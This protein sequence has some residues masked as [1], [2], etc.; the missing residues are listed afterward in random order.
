MARSAS[1][2]PQ[3]LAEGGIIDRQRTIQ[4]TF[5]GVTY[6]GHFGDTVASALLA[7]GVILTGRS[8]KYHRPRGIFSAGSEEPNALVE[9]RS[10]AYREPNTKATMAEL[11]DGLEATSQNRWPS[12]NFD[13]LSLN[14]ALA[15]IFVAGFYYKT[16]MWPSALW[17]R[18]YEPAIRRAAGLGR[19]ADG[20]DP[21]SYEKMTVHTDVLVIGGGPAGL[22]SALAAAGSGARVILADEHAALG[23]RAIDDAAMIDGKTAHD[24]VRSVE[25]EL[26]RNGN[27][28]VLRRTS[29]FGT[30]D[31]GTYGAVER[32]SDHLA[33]APGGLPRQRIWRIVA[34]HVVLASGATERPIVF[35]NNDRPGVMLAGAVRSYINRY[36]VV[37]GQRV[38]VFTNND[39]G[40]S[41]I[42]DL[43]RAGAEVVAVVDSRPKPSETV[44]RLASSVGTKL[45]TGTVITKALGRKRVRSAIVRTQSGAELRLDC[46]LIA[47]SGGWN[48]NIQLSTH[49]GSKP[50]WNERHH[51]FLAGTLPSG[52]SLAGAVAGDFSL[53]KTLSGGAAAGSA[54]GAASG[55]EPVAVQPPLAVGESE[56]ITPLWRVKSPA[57]KAFVDQQN[58][59][60][61]KDIELAEREGFRAVEHMK[62]YTTLGMATDQGRTANVNALAIMA[63]ITG[64]TIP[65]I[66]LARPPY[67]PVAVGALA[68]HHRGKSFKPTRLPPS[69]RWAK[70]QGAMFVE[71][72]LWLRPSYFPRAGERDWLETV[73]RE[74]NTVRSA[75][76]ICDVSTLGKIDLQGADA[77][78]FLDRIYMN[79]L[80]TLAVGKARYGGMLREDGIFFDDGTI[81]RFG[82]HHYF[83]TTTTANAVKVL[84]HMEYCHQ[85]LWP[86]L[87]V[88]M[89]SATEQ[90]AQYAV[91]G[92]KSRALLQKVVDPA[93]DISDAGFPYLQVGGVT[94]CGGVKARLF[95]LSFSGERA[96]EIGVPARYGDALMR[97]LWEAGREFGACA[98]G[99]EALGVMRIEKGHISG[100]E[101]NGTTTPHDLGLGGMVSTKKDF[102]GR[103][104][105]ARPGLLDPDR[106]ALI[107]FRPI[108]RSA[109]L[110]AGAHF[111][112]RGAKATAANDEGYMTSV[113]YSPSN[114]HWVGLGL[115]KHGPKRIGEIVRAY[116]PLRGGDTLVEVVSPVFVDPEGVRVRG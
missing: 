1:T 28:R 111:L 9:L 30:Y 25:D 32:V 73:A 59:V 39:Y 112:A 97:R 27:V 58:D 101:L 107:G 19:A 61:D 87:D 3:R 72:G 35:G 31:G 45:I 24:W 90:W 95:R 26:T 33:V 49:L 113:A 41:T 80:K 99:T 34:K 86:E 74:V 82:E 2:Q 62:R 77:A 88:Q 43:A 114:G 91:A 14:S 10:G 65:G 54:A 44:A 17:E 98:Y 15:P 60:T 38:I 5:D 76:G 81:A 63:E 106:P 71:A 83:I 116:D 110:R 47:V 92:P 36:G 78:V 53:P 4:F 21:D 75:V 57:G 84:Q 56:D 48:P 100:P 89:I 68:G 37:P 8:F 18:V 115:L 46:D 79:G 67:V 16:F 109:R 69:Y 102:V 11:F 52:M 13:V 42:T 51:C 29:V 12:L 104:L 20:A 94:V 85:W 50:Q 6:S 70:E 93:F 64:R 7:N 96:Y 55:S 66:T 40:A 105:A 23:G 103:V 22:M 108:K